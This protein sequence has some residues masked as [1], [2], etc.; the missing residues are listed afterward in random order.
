MTLVNIRVNVQPETEEKIN[1]LSDATG[2]DRGMVVDEAIAA[3]N[4]IDPQTVFDRMEQRL[5]SE[6][7]QRLE[8]LRDT[9]GI[10]RGK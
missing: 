9:L 8:R 2:L 6:K 3:M 4:E 5:E 10:D 1:S 7:A